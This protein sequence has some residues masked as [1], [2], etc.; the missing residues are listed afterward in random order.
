MTRAVKM[1]GRV[2]DTYIEEGIRPP[3]SGPIKGSLGE[4]TVEAVVRSG[5]C[6]RGSSPGLAGMGRA[7]REEDEVTRSVLNSSVPVRA[8]LNVP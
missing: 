1:Y 5:V 8:S 7:G 3:M 6:I 2:P 4:R